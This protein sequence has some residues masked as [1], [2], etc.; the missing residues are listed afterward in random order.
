MYDILK[1]SFNI[2]SLTELYSLKFSFKIHSHHANEVLH[3]SLQ[4]QLPNW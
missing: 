2:L 1:L 3:S 4:K